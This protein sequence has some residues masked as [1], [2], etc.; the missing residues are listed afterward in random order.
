MIEIFYCYAHEDTML[1]SGLETHLSTLKLLGLISGWHERAIQSGK[2]REREIDIHLNSANI[3]L[4]LVSSDFMASEQ[5]HSIM[6][7]AFEKHKVGA[8]YVIPI[9]LRPVDVVNTPIGKLQVLPT[10]GKPVTRWRNRDEAFLNVAR[11]I[12]EVISTLLSQKNKEERNR[13][14]RQVNQALYRMINTKEAVHLFHD[15]MQPD[16]QVKILRIVGEGN[17]G[18]SHL[19]TKIFPVLARQDYRARYVVLDLRNPVCTVHDILEDACRQ[20]GI[21]TLEKYTTTNNAISGIEE[22]HSKNSHLASYFAKELS[23]LSDETLLL[24][25]DSVNNAT[26]TM[27]TWLMNIFLV[28][29]SSLSHVRVVIA[30]R[31]LPEIHGSYAAICR[32][33]Y[34][35]F[36]IID[37]EEY[38]DYCQRLNARLAE[39]S[40]RD[41]AYACYYTPGLFASLVCPF[42]P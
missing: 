16:S 17:M 15:L 1:L 39:Q 14:V 12:R 42:V 37:E 35:L 25:F 36:P 10:G 30:G 40:I 18:K 26:E 34:K 6:R 28:E 33:P 31:T 21:Q 19:L 24:L 29:I 38:I 7:Q 4:L 8:A 11:G 9:I 2:E 3:I 22:I 13:S 5:C 32:D 23:Q 27:Q 20:L 41:F